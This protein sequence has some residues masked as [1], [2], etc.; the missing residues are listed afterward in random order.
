MAT[1]LVRKMCSAKLFRKGQRSITTTSRLS[2]AGYK[3]LLEDRDIELLKKKIGDLEATPAPNLADKNVTFEALFRRSKFCQLG[4]I[5]NSIVMGKVI[6][7][8]CDDLYIDFGGKFHCVCP[9]PLTTEIVKNEETGKEEIIQR[10]DDSY[11]YGTR[12][13]LLLKEFEMADKFLGSAR[14]TSLLE[15]DAVLLGHVTQKE[16]LQEELQENIL[17]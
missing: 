7:V 1:N 11:T 17:Y 14:Y 9:R 8:V 10:F 16:I 3:K 13:K 12:V 15:A 2:V 6:D 5:S 4:D